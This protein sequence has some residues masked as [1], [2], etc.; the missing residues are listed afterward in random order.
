M[1]SQD[2]PP[3]TTAIKPCGEIDLAAIRISHGAHGGT[4]QGACCVIE[5]SNLLATCNVELRERFGKPDKFADDHPSISRVIR[6]L[7]IALNDRWLNSDGGPK[8]WWAPD[9]G[10]AL[11][12][13]YAERVLGT[14]T[15]E[16]DEQ[17]RRY[18]CIGWAA[19]VAA[20]MWLDAV[21]RAEDAET[22]RALPEI[23]NEQTR[24]AARKILR[25][26]ADAA[27]LR[28]S[29]AWDRYWGARRRRQ[30]AE[31]AAAAEAA[32]AEVAVAAVAA[33][34]AEAAAAVPAARAS[35][36]SSSARPLRT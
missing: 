3:M 13:P 26:I 12:R 14:A 29:E 9:D 10:E 32:A 4:F 15:T 33:A 22:L 17:I 27:W 11:L 23:V 18:L 16:A 25:S 1:T 31:G 24:T 2:N 20:P 28:R 34:A 19:R 5:Y 8:G 21:G 36:S 35:G 30:S 7:C 6:R